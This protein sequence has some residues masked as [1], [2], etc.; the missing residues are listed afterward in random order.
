MKFYCFALLLTSLLANSLNSITLGLFVGSEN[1]LQMS[2][3]AYNSMRIRISWS[4]QK[5]TRYQIV[6]A[7]YNG[8]NGTLVGL[9]CNFSLHFVA[10]MVFGF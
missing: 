5:D 1:I 4:I 2:N 6:C 7:E 3:H 9:H 8:K 10:W